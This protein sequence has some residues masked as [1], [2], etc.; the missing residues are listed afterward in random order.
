MF[1][2][3]YNNN[4]DYYFEDKTVSELCELV[5]RIPEGTH[6][7]IVECKL[8]SILMYFIL[9]SS[10]WAAFTKLRKSVLQLLSYF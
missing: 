2:C 9:Y 7:V 5:K 6:R 3:R 8:P 10:V 1:S 4:L